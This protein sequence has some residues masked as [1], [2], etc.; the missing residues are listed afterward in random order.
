M[1]DLFCERR[2]LRNFVVVRKAYKNINSIYLRGNY[3]EFLNGTEVS[4]FSPKLSLLDLKRN[5]LKKVRNGTFKGFWEQK[6]LHIS[7]NN[8]AEID[9]N[10]FSQLVKL[11]Q[12]DMRYNK[13]K[14]VKDIWF[15][16][17][18]ELE[19]IDLKTT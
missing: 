9:F 3:I 15:R 13:I 11:N 10:A 8:I 19:I 7:K 17:L 2:N 18:N 5:R 12:L 14:I 1:T 4:K 16:R 6:L